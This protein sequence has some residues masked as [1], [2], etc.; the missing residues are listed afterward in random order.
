MNR[1]PLNRKY[2]EIYILIVIL[3]IA[4]LLSNQ[5]SADTG[6]RFLKQSDSAEQAALGGGATAMGWNSLFSNPAGLAGRQEQGIQVGHA[7]LPQEIS[8]QN[9]RYAGRKGGFGY[10][11]GVLHATSGS[12]PGYDADFNPLGDFKA[13]EMG[14]EFGLAGH[15]CGGLRLGVAGKLI[16][17]SIEDES[18]RGFAGD[19]GVQLQAPFARWLVLGAAMR[20]MGD[21]LVFV[22]DE[23]PLP[24]EFEVGAEIRS[25]RL[26]LLAGA[27]RGEDDLWQADLGLELGLLEGL[28][29]RGAIEMHPE[30][31][32]RINAGF[33]LHLGSLR[34]DYA[35]GIHEDLAETHRIGV[36]LLGN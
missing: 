9:L 4:L 19:A 32:H 13:R 3:S 35:Y 10:G 36:G 28:Q 24:R 16:E 29:I 20:N 30:R 17:Q 21:P 2:L 18:A 27:T 15:L 11:I 33:G 25:R 1:K 26:R 14:V 5:S 23:D 34:L 7:Q 8:I 6:A 22:A 12:I 31:D